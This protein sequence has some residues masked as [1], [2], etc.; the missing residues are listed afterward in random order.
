MGLFAFGGIARFSKKK[1]LYNQ[2]IYHFDQIKLTWI[3]VATLPTPRMQPKL[4]L[5]RSGTHVYLLGGELGIPPDNLSAIRF[6]I[7]TSK[8]E[9]LI[10]YGYLNPLKPLSTKQTHAIFH[11]SEE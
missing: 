10:D 3:P 9:N 5:S 4:T 1:M 7:L 6:N 2:D 8:V 11:V